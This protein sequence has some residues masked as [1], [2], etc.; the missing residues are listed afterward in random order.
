MCAA[1]KN[2]PASLAPG[3]VTTRV[4]GDES[5]P[6]IKTSVP[7]PTVTFHK[8]LMVIVAVAQGPIKKIIIII[9]KQI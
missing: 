1:I 7:Q 2:R 4:L 6:H 3:W 8:K 9:Q 5:L